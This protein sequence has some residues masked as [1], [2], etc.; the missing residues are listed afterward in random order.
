MTKSWEMA[1]VGPRT[2]GNS[3]IGNSTKTEGRHHIDMIWRI[4]RWLR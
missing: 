4:V 2:K 1:K 3:E